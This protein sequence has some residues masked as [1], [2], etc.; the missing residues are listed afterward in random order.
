MTP[1]EITGI[2]G[3]IVTA[4]ALVVVPYLLRRGDK[5]KQLD[6]T[7]VVSWE[8]MNAV[9]Q[10]QNTKLQAAQEELESRNRKKQREMET[11]YTQQLETARTRINGLERTIAEL[12]EQLGRLRS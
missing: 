12:Y 8:K 11:D 10:E 7:Q 5:R 9:L 6:E 4:I 3:L 1:T 2:G